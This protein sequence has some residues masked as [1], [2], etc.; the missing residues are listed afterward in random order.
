MEEGGRVVF[1]GTQ[2][3]SPPLVLGS[4]LVIPAMLNGPMPDPFTPI[5]LTPASLIIFMYI[6]ITGLKFNL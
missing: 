1:G 3:W 5:S 4:F 6:S 2:R